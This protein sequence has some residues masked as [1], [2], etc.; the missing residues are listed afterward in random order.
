MFGRN[1]K[2][3]HRKFVNDTDRLLI[4]EEL[5]LDAT[6]AH[7]YKTCSDGSAS[8]ETAFQH[9]SVYKSSSLWL[10]IESNP[11]S[12]VIVV[13]VIIEIDRKLSQNT[14]IRVGDLIVGINGSS[15]YDQM[16]SVD[17]VLGEMYTMDKDTRI[18]ILRL[19][20][21]ETGST[22]ACVHN[23][24][25][26]QIDINTRGRDPTKAS[27]L[28]PRNTLSL[29][30]GNGPVRQ[31]L[32]CDVA[33]MAQRV[34]VT[35]VDAQG[36]ARKLHPGDIICSINGVVL[37]ELQGQYCMAVLAAAQSFIWHSACAA[38]T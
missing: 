29:H 20:G 31:S 24:D 15:T 11:N 32:G 37:G 5:Y 30:R 27:D 6:I 21:A 13:P 9:V 23:I 18:R 14:G 4:S 2:R 35:H 19:R 22:N 33:I 10:E 7:E 28:E 16:I 34:V 38:T 36:L 12:N 8:L 1:D 26:V 3:D 17:K 25:D